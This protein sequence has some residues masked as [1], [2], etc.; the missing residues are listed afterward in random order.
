MCTTNE[1]YSLELHKCIKKIDC[2][3]DE[4]YDDKVKRC[5]KKSSLCTEF[6]KYDEATQQCIK[7]NYITSPYLENIVYTS[8][9][10]KDYIALYESRVAKEG[11]KDCPLSQPYYNTITKKC[12]NC[13]SSNPYFD[14]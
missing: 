9:Y 8:G 13:P 11:L 14:L 10:F 5:V 6:E 2:K 1:T 4:F 3:T 12:M 7:F